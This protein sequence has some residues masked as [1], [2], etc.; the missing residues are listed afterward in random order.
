[1]S[2]KKKALYIF[3]II[4]ITFE[5]RVALVYGAVKFDFIMEFLNSGYGIFNKLI[6][7]ILKLA[8]FFGTF[9]VLKKPKNIEW[10]PEEG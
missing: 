1:M 7:A 5:L 4:L 2:T 10:N 3:L 9:I 8:P 6:S